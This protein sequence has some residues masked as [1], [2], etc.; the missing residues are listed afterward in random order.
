MDLIQGTHED[1][2]SSWHGWSL[3]TH[4]EEHL[5]IGTLPGRKRIA[6]YVHHRIPWTDEKGVTHTGATIRPV[7]YFKTPE[8][9]KKVMDLIDLLAFS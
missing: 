8:D 6:I 2:Q 5:H 3:S 9:A 4:P 7:A 1:D